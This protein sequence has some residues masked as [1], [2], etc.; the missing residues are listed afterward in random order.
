MLTDKLYI[1]SYGNVA[2]INKKT[3]AIIWEKKLKDYISSMTSYSVGQIQIEGDK[4]YIG[5]SGQ[6]LCLRAK[7]GSLVWKNDLKGWGYNFISFANQPVEAIV[8]MQ[9]QQAEM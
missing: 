3:G 6:M 9:Q 7:D 2:A 1:L 8:A 4:L 5:V